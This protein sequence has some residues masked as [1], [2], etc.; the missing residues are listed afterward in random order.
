[1]SVRKISIRMSGLA[2]AV[3][4]ALHGAAAFAG[5]NANATPADAAATDHSKAK[6]L[7]AISVVAP[8]ETI[9]VQSV[10]SVDIKALPPGSSAFKALDQL[11]GVNFQSS[12]PW[13]AYEW[14]TQITL[15]G[16]DQSRLGFTLDNIPLGNMSYGVTNGLQVTR[17]ITSD[18]L[19]SV[20]IAQGAGALGTPSSTNLGGTVQFYSADPDAAPGARVSQAFASD[21]TY[22]TFVRLDSGDFH[23]YSMYV[24]FARADTGKWKG[25]GDQQDNQLN[26]KSLYQ[27]GDGNRVS[28]F[29]D[30]SKRKEYDYQDLSLTSQRV[31][32]WNYD[33]WQ[34]DWTSAVQTALAMQGKGAYPASLNGLPADYD[35]GDVN[36]YAG[37]GIRRDNLVGLSG[38]FSLAS[39]ATLNLGT[40]YHNDRGEGQW[41]TPYVA[42]SAT[43]PIAMRTT[44][45]GLDRTG[46]TA[47][48]DFTVANND[49]QVGAWVE[50]AN[51]NQERNYFLLNGQYSFLSNFYDS[52]QPFAR[53]FFQNYQTTTR[54]GYI[55][56]TLHLLDDRLTVNFGSKALDVT[57]TAKSLEPS[58]LSAGRISA[59]DNFL[60]QAGVDYKLD[61]HQDVYASYTKNM[62]AYGFLPFSQSQASFDGAKSN[63]KP[64]ESQTF[65]L[66]YR[67]QGAGFEA[68]ADAYYTHFTNRLLSVSPCSAVQTCSAIINNVGSV[69]SKGLDLALIWKPMEHMRWLN[70]LSYANTKYE[71]DYLNNGVVATAGKYV[72]GTPVWMFTSALSYTVGGFTFNVDGKYT[73]RRYITYINDSSVPSYWLL[74]AGVNY[75]VGAVSILKD[76]SFS[77]NVTNLANEHYFATTGTN[78]YV[79]SDPSGY[80]QTLQAGAPRQYFFNINAKF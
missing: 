22:R 6:S 66:G 56:D 64:E 47:S 69:K 72:V 9:Q 35:K 51:T 15:H 12:D 62:A 46:G 76:L 33:Y 49:I 41:A 1:M 55:Q 30:S 78:G 24:S 43:V 2:L 20:E 48:L 5:D 32:G 21:S 61:Q 50:D 4:A 29:V 63:L 53:G 59:R 27:W 54:M 44:D 45:Y 36:Y 34:P 8:G 38:Q 68:S 13:G 77:F 17:A 58:A 25:Y 18:N 10:S 11:P 42:S 74:N 28:L 37:G 26:L 80:N 3:V 75:D 65:E 23:G 16:F 52:E 40:Y 70:T 14:S 19:S 67:V 39:N 71:N 7:D 73:G 57:T 31:L 79:A 60:P